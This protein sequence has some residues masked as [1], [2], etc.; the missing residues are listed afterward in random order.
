[1]YR[2]YGIQGWKRPRTQLRKI[3]NRCSPRW[4]AL[5]TYQ[6]AGSHKNAPATGRTG[7]MT[8]STTVKI[9]IFPNKKR[10]TTDDCVLRA[11]MAAAR[12]EFLRANRCISGGLSWG[13]KRRQRDT[14]VLMISF[15]TSDS[16]FYSLLP[17]RAPIQ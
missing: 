8:T 9:L 10:H 3:K 4:V 12:A 11:A 6:P 15:P 16:Q 5:R 14:N 13:R 17:R 1:M 7:W 2:R